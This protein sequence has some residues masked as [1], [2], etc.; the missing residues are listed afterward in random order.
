MVLSKLKKQVVIKNYEISTKNKSD[1]I[2][3]DPNDN[4]G[5]EVNG[6][7][8]IVFDDT[9]HWHFYDLK[10]DTDFI[11][12]VTNLLVWLLTLPIDFE[13]DAIYCAVNQERTRYYEIYENNGEFNS[14]LCRT[15]SPVIKRQIVITEVHE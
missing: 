13:P 7:D 12:R 2:I 9:D 5:F 4:I 8:I 3:V 11:D 6:R 1:V 10:K 15:N 14:V